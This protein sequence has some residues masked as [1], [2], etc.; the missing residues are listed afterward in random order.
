MSKLK[1]YFI[2]FLSLFPLSAGAIV[3]WLIAG[4]VLTIAGFSIWRSTSP[5]NMNDAFSFFSS[6]WTCEMFSS[7]MSTMSNILPPIYSGIGKAVIPMAVMLTIVYFTW[8]IASGFLNSKIESGWNLTSQ[9]GTHTIRLAIVCALLLFP[10]P[11]LIT[12]VVIDPIFNIG[13]SV[14]HI[15]GDTAEFSKCMVATTLMDGETATESVAIDDTRRGAFPIK[16]RAGLTCEL[17]AVHQVTGLGMTVGWTMLN[18]AFNNQ[19]MHKIMWDIPVFPNIP[20]LF[21]GLLVLAL[22][23]TAML[24]IPL[25]FL[26]I[27]ITLALDLVMLPLMLFAWLFKGWAIFPQGGKNIQ[28]MIND[29]IKGTVGIAMTVVFLL[30]GM[31]FLDA[32]VGSIGGISRIATA[33]AQND[34]TILM[35][36]LLMRD[37]GLLSV[38]LMGVFFALFMTSIPNLIKSLFNVQISDKFYATAKKDFDTTRATLGKW[39]KKLKN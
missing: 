18:M 24:P 31:M 37:D 11:R 4:G 38:I 1:K 39:W 26:E 29:V 22:Y 28:G 21:A 9:F 6:C 27:F 10:L 25:Y 14:N 13:L 20:I 35:D 5:V 12:G 36:G 16:L 2:A 15:I 34:S 7:V 33:I 19:Y 23:F 30:F 17:A 32:I 8:T 3:P